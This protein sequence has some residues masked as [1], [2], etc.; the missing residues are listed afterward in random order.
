[1]RL[2][3]RDED[4]LE[5]M[6]FKLLI[7]SVVLAMA[8]PTMY[9][10]VEYYDTRKVL[11]DLKSEV[12]FIGEKAEQVFIHGTGNS[13]VIEFDLK[14]GIFERIE[15]VKL[16]GGPD[17]IIRWNTSEHD[18]KY[19]LPKKIPLYNESGVKKLSEGRH[20]LRL[21]CKFGDPGDHFDQNTQYVEVE[22]ID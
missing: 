12:R 9:S 3:R 4:G 19:V 18:G 13:E 10:S 2:I 14:N 5:G 6:P 1:M 7:I 8:I 11:Q 20:E 17:H 15:S 22:V 16:C 21:T